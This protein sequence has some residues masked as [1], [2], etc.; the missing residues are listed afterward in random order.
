MGSLSSRLELT[1]VLETQVN[2]H[3]WSKL[4]F[5]EELVWYEVEY[6]DFFSQEKETLFVPIVSEMGSR[7]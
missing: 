6:I 3:T 4:S 1:R 2:P 5:E 7:R